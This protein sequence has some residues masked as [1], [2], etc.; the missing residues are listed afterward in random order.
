M[1]GIARARDDG[2][3][4]TQTA[5]GLHD[6]FGSGR[7]IDSDDQRPRL[8]QAAAQEKFRPRRIPPINVDAFAPPGFDI[9]GI[10]I[11]GEERNLVHAQHLADELADAAEAD[12]NHFMLASI[13]VEARKPRQFG[14]IGRDGP[15]H[16]A[17]QSAE[18]WNGE[19]R[20]GDGD[21]G[22]GAETR[23]QHLGHDRAGDHDEGE[24]AARPEHQRR[25]RRRSL[26][27]KRRLRPAT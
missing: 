19:H 13:L 8:R 1:F 6:L 21:H 2:Q 14:I 7:R 26:C 18:Q 3:I 23:R 9:G 22:I 10:G 25:F 17:R 20:Q 5:R 11:D 24:F 12:E 16:P 15:R 4:V 27:G